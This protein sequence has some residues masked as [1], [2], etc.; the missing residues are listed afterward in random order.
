[1]FACYADDDVFDAMQVPVEFPEQ[2][3]T[4]SS[5]PMLHPLLR[6]ADRKVGIPR[7]PVRSFGRAVLVQYMPSSELRAGR[8]FSSRLRSALRGMKTFDVSP[9]T[10]SATLAA[11]AAAVHGADRVIV[12]TYVRRIEGEGR[13]AIP[14][15][16]AAF[17]DSLGA[18]ER[19]V[20][21]SFGNPY[22][23]RQFPSVGTYLVT[24][25]VAD[26]LEDAAADALLGRTP[27]TGRIPVSLPGFFVRGDGLRRDAMTN[28]R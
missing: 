24:Y 16:I 9:S 3:V 23:I 15:P 2:L 13:F 28:E 10:D 17:I 1:V 4:V 14:A 22:L 8:V 20:V 6:V 7:A 12:A 11:V 27:I 18:R 25:G 5:L 26:V 19:S 21:V